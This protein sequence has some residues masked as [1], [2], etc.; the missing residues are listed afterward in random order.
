MRKKNAPLEVPDELRGDFYMALTA[1]ENVCFIGDS[2]TEGTRNGGV[3]YFEPLENLIRGKIFNVSKGG[4]TSKLLLERVDE[5]IQ[6]RA[7]L[8]VVAVGAN[9]VRYRDAE[10]CSMTPEEYVATLQKILEAVRKKIPAAKFVFIAPWTSTDGD[11]VS[12]L[13]FD[14]KIKLNGEYS[15]A[16][17]NFCLANGEI[18]VDPNP[19]IEAHLKIFPREKFLVD[20][21]HPN[22]DN[23]VELYAEAV[24]R[25]DSR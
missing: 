9:D 13:P 14:E 3:P 5:I 19:F 15:T 20:F 25:G 10:I 17:K 11:F 4:A 12:E 6:S 8:F 22:A 7:D 18:F 1:A 24:L 2:L 16:L 23:G 21:I